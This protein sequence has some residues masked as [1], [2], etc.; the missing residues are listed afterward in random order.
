MRRVLMVMVVFGV[1]GCAAVA[2]SD[3][4]TGSRR[5]DAASASSMLAIKEVTVFKDGHAFV[6]HEGTL[7]VDGAGDVVMDYLPAPVLGTFW[8][9]TPDK[10]P[11]LTS[12]VSGKHR[13]TL[14]RTSLT[15]RELLEANV[16]AEGVITETS[17]NHYPATIVGVPARSGQEL[18]ATSPPNTDPKLPEKGSIV[19]LKT[20]EGT[21]ALPIERIQDVTFKE[22]PRSAVSSEE[23]RNMLTLKLD[24]AGKPPEKTAP[25]GLGYLQKGLRWIPSYKVTIDGEGKAMVALQATLVNELADL[26]DV[27]AHLVIGVPSFALKDTL[28]PISFQQVLAQ[29]TQL[30]GRRYDNNFNFS[31]A[32]MSQSQAVQPFTDARGPTPSSSDEQPRDLGPE[33]TGSTRNE[34]LFVFSVQHIT[35]KK[36]QRMVLP[37]A[38]FTLKY[39]DVFTLDVPFTPPPEIRGNFNNEQQAEMARLFYAPKVMHKI[40]L[41]NSSKYPLT[42]AP[43]LIVKGD[44]VLSQGMMTYAAP[45]SSADVDVT[46]AVEI[47]VRK[48]DN[49]TKRTPNAAQ[50][51][52]N[53]Y[54][55]IDLEGMISLTSHRKQPVE[56]E[57]TRSALGSIESADHD[58]K[59]EMANVFEDGKYM[60]NGDYPYWWNWYSWPYWWHHFNGVG[61]VTWK[62]TLEPEKRMD[63]G[64]K[65]NYY[66][67]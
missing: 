51:E 52:G 7:P 2:V 35:L 32:I 53:Q 60:A 3:T 24:W 18:E 31:N 62:V 58:G 49:E 15:V 39:Q 46:A 45:G 61:R 29:V 28:D 6:V 47:Q 11:R 48:T 66:W 33:V 26:K 64:Y 10:G 17:G 25:V 54:S 27:T 34:D 22:V 23:F 1:A 38:E 42:T 20:H 44:R 14:E 16:G 63:L 13:V 56:V 5:H 30:Q 65:W 8:P 67:R 37:V 9:Y 43:A 41:T 19:L 36:G 4:T 12:V 55:R 57:V 59:I 40:R 21:K 50:W